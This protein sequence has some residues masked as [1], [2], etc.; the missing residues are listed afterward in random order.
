MKTLRQ[1][2]ILALGA[3]IL[4][5][6]ARLIPAV[7]QPFETSLTTSNFNENFDELTPECTG[8]DLPAGWVMAQGVGLPKY[9]SALAPATVT[10]WTL[11]APTNYTNYEWV[12]EGGA[13]GC[14]HDVS[15]GGTFGGRINFG[16]EASSYA[17]RCLG[18][19]SSNPSIE[20]P[21]NDFM[22][23]FT[24]NTGSNILSIA[25]TNNIKLYGYNTFPAMVY[26]YYSLDGT[27][28]TAVSA[29]NVGPFPTTA[30][31]NT[32]L[33]TS[34][35]YV[36]NVSLTIANLNIPNGSPFY[37]NW[38]FVVSS[39]NGSFS[40][41]IGLDDV[42]LTA[43][44]GSAPPPPGNSVWPSGAG[45]W[46]VATDWQGGS[47]PVSGNNLIFDGPGGAMNNNLAAVSTGTGTVESMLFS[48]T[49]SG[50]YTLS[51]NAITVA[52]GITNASS[53]L[54][55]LN[56]PLTL[57]QDETFSATAGAFTFQNNITNGG[58]NV[59]FSGASS[60]T[61]NGAETGAGSLTMDGAGLLAIDGANTYTGA[62]TVNSGT[63]RLEASGSIASS[64][65]VSVDSGATLDLASN[66]ATIANLSGNGNVTLGTGTL[67]INGATGTDTFGG[68]ISGSG[69]LTFDGGLTQILTGTNSYNGPTT[70]TSGTLAVAAP[71]SIGSG[72]LL[73]Q[74][75]TF[76]T[77]G[78]R[79]VTLEVLSNDFVLAADSIVQNTTSAAGG[80]RNLPFGGAVVATNGTLTIQNIATANTNV[81]Y[82]RFTGS[83]TNF[84]QPIVFDNS[85]AG[86][87]T[88]NLSQVGSG[89]TNGSAP[90]VFSGL[91]SG[92]GYFARDAQVA[93]TGGMTILTGQNTFIYD[94][95]VMHGYVGIGADSV[96][97]GGSLASSPVGLGNIQITDDTINGVA[98]VGLFAA[99]GAH[100][101]ANTV[102]LNGV[103]NT[104][105]IGS[106][107]L[108][109]AGVFNVGASSKILTVSN[110]G[111]TTISGGLTNSGSLT[112]TGPGTLEL[113]ADSATNWTGAMAIADGTL[114]A[115]N[116]S[117]SAT[118]S[119]AVSVTGGILAGTGYVSGAVVAT[120][121]GV[122]PG[123]AVGTLT[124]SN[125]L[126]LSGGGALIWNLGAESTSNPGSSFSQLALAG[127]AL[128][129]GGSSVLTLSFDSPASAPI[130]TDP[131]WQTTESWQIVV[132]SGGAT[133]T[134]GN[135]SSIS[136]GTYAAGYFST[137]VNAGGILLKYTPG[138]VS[139]KQ[140]DIAAVSLSGTQLSLVVSNGTSGQAFYVVTA[141]NLTLPFSHWAV[142]STNNFSGN[143]T[144][145]NI[146]TYSPS[147]SQ[148]FFGIK[149]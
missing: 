68:A 2:K 16:D 111:L 67:T 46:N 93:G 108:N 142:V 52:T 10:N 137:T 23:G 55:T 75:G 118:G 85:L 131:F 143:G 121:G 110:T 139:V 66:N 12:E 5:V 91:I 4:A 127:G 149:D 51:G 115:D 100:T 125:G 128:N 34:G 76:Q 144:C 122:S 3:V 64:S 135:F 88:L 41:S 90:Q 92:P 54:Q 31:G 104:A 101:V 6:G 72:Q 83:V 49:A 123:N 1:I 80:T 133:V 50:S 147:D 94:T 15:P 71:A 57:I 120:S 82:L 13:S 89:N 33:Y 60:I 70:L 22:L 40:A 48:N 95:L 103:T 113:T 132:L 44:L 86:S 81:I 11:I 53:F 30:T 42:G 119:N 78:T 32:F 17:N 105:I 25:V 148:R 97:I 77:T 61:L 141:T 96:S 129:L 73:L 24:N 19:R 8:A 20:C 106:N 107:N 21:T 62:T 98:G 9:D 112:K 28:W 84:A 37:L 26:F 116:T 102:V 69:G 59:I 117:G 65:G 124:L 74:G 18:F 63:L 130:A 45:N 79:S 126:D 47:L 109:L 145:T 38:Q 99:G 14:T 87:S 138:A 146:I 56:V 7:A 36:S 114:L 136:D 43:T 35:P 29:G 140:P 134:G 27:N 39:A 58:N